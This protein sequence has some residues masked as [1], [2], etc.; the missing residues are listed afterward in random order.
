MSEG[1]F[2]RA[3]REEMATAQHE[4]LV[5]TYM[6]ANGM[7]YGSQAGLRERGEAWAKQIEDA[8]KAQEA[9]RVIAE[10]RACPECGR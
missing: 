1:A 10:A 6:W 3:F 5:E 9:L 8:G 2:I 7:G 4:A